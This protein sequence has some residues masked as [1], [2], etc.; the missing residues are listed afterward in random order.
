M[1]VD[2]RLG[3]INEF[4]NDGWVRCWSK[5]GGDNLY[6]LAE[7]GPFDVYLDGVYFPYPEAIEN[8]IERSLLDQDRRGPKLRANGSMPM[9]LC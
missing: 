3:P 9:N 4:E 7:L 8:V 5:R 6:H 1:A 2:A